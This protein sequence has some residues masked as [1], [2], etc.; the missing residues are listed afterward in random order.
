MK[1]TIYLVGNHIDTIVYG[2][3]LVSKEPLYKKTIPPTEFLNSLQFKDKLKFFAD[4]DQAEAHSQAN[5]IIKS[6][7]GEE[8]ILRQPAVFTVE[9]ESTWEVFVTQ[10]FS[11]YIKFPGKK[12]YP[13]LISFNTKLDPVLTTFLATVKCTKDNFEGDFRVVDSGGLRHFLCQNKEHG[14]TPENQTNMYQLPLDVTRN[15]CDYVMEETR[16]RIRKR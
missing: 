8:M 9:V 2:N 1:R 5:A 14:L 4:R 6:L 13:Y 15:I 11:A 3:F 12:I 7:K 16:P 10:I